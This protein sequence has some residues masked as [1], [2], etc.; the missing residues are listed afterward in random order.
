MPNCE[1]A[2]AEIISALL[3]TPD[4]VGYPGNLPLT[5]HCV[6]AVTSSDHLGRYLY[7]IKQEEDDDEETNKDKPARIHPLLCSPSPERALFLSLVRSGRCLFLS[8]PTRP[9]A[10]GDA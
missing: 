2:P 7:G 5:R 1:V 10:A 6:T 4:V 9:A 8:T 3:P